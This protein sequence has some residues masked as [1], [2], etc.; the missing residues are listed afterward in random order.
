MSVGLES[1][2]ATRVRG[3]R[4]S[5]VYTRATT[6]LCSPGKIER[7]TKK[8]QKQRETETD[9]ESE[10]ERE[11]EEEEEKEEKRGWFSIMVAVRVQFGNPISQSRTRL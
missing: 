4:V 3:G 8:A 5:N 6:P 10:R 1:N 9:K 2:V 7:L 11:R